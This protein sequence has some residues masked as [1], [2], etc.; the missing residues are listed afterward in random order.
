M[1]LCAD[2]P[3][4]TLSYLINNRYLAQKAL[5]FPPLN[6]A[7]TTMERTSPA[8]WC[9]HD[10]FTSFPVEKMQCCKCNNAVRFLHIPRCLGSNQIRL[11]L[12]ICTGDIMA[13]L[14]WIHWAIK[15][16]VWS[17]R[18]TLEASET[19][20]KQGLIQVQ[21]TDQLFDIDKK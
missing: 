7:L 1:A 3:P 20:G 11:S 10:W 15:K 8:S 18:K 4:H 19:Y 9:Y 2:R 13:H 12:T 21:R 14:I 6:C 16:E 17:L 5:C